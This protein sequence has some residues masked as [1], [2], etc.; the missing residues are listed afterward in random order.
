[1]RVAITGRVRVS[2]QCSAYTVDSSVKQ[3]EKQE[4]LKVPNEQRETDRDGERD[5]GSE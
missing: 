2:D 5:E 1:M 3:A 4:A